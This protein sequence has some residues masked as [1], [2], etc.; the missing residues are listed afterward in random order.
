M[1]AVGAQALRSRPMNN[2][3]CTHKYHTTM[4][5]EGGGEVGVYAYTR[6]I[7]HGIHPHCPSPTQTGGEGH[8][9]VHIPKW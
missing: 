6:D 7:M 9:C 2:T 4:G 8:G 3:L 1:R 5:K